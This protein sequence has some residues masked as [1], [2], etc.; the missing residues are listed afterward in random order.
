MKEVIKIRKYSRIIILGNGKIAYDCL[1]SLY[2]RAYEFI[3]IESQYNSFSMLKT[4]CDKLTIPYYSFETRE[5]IMGVIQEYFGDEV[6]LLISANNENI[7]PKEICDMDNLDIINFHYSYLPDYRGMNIPTW[8]IYNNEPFTGVTWHFV[9]ANIDDGQIIAQRKID[10]CESSRALDIVQEG[11]ILG[12]AIFEGI[13]D[14][15]LEGEIINQH[16]SS[17]ECVHSY[18]RKELPCN[19]FFD[20]NI[21][22]DTLTRLLRAYDYGVA[23]NISP[24]VFS[25]DNV[26]YKIKKY[27]FY[28]KN[29]LVVG[30]ENWNPDYSFEKEDLKIEFL[31]SKK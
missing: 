11:M 23:K 13:I 27:R 4:K 29:I 10:I 14:K 8:V 15:L 24:L 3:V 5:Q 22:A 25:L 6:S 28:K 21:G 7:I 26:N 2:K 30:K 9:N 17:G 31:F 12:G 19:G 1:E 16:I 20:I 18:K